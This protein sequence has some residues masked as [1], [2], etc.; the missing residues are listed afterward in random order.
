MA[1]RSDAVDVPL[2]LVVRSQD[3]LAAA[4]SDGMSRMMRAEQ[5]QV[6]RPVR[7]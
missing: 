3:A 6:R 4:L 5:R 2:K 1:E 7:S